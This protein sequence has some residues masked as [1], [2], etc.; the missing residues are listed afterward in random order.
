[1][2]TYLVIPTSHPVIEEPVHLRV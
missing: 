2:L 1:V